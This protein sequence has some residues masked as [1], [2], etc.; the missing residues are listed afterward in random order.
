MTSNKQGLVSRMRIAFG[1]TALG[2]IAATALAAPAASQEKFTGEIFMVS[3]DW[4]P[5]G[6]LAADGQTLPVSSYQ[7]L[8]SLITTTYGGNGRT[9]FALPD[10]RGRAPVHAGKAGGRPERAI[11]STTRNSG[12]ATASEAPGSVQV[13]DQTLAVKMCIVFDG[14]YPVRY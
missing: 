8:F 7:A 12:H 14:R 2:T 1:A 9:D 6:S 3:T 5:Q 10:L 13:S 4:C 11:G